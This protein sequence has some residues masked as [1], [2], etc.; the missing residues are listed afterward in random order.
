MTLDATGSWSVLGGGAADVT[1]RLVGG[2]L[3]I[4]TAL[5]GTPYGDVGGFG[6]RT[7]TRG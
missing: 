6:A 2:C 7:P 5:A 3:E 4:L 1:G